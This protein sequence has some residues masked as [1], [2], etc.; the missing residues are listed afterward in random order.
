MKTNKKSSVKIEKGE[1]KQMRIQRGLNVMLVIMVL[2][3]G[4][5]SVPDTVRAAEKKTV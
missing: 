1:E 3:L 2:L 5:L 4:V